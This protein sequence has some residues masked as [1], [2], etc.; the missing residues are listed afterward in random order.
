MSPDEPDQVTGET[1]DR[2]PGQGRYATTERERR[3]LLDRVPDGVS[4]PV[5]ILD[6]YIHA[7]TLRL[8]QMQSARQ[9]V[10]KL[11][12]KVRPD[13]ERPSVNQVT[14]L[15]LTEREF[16]I[17]DQLPGDALSKTRWR[18]AVGGRV[19]SVDQYRGQLDGLVLAEIE[20]SGALPV[21]PP[22]SC[23]LAEVTQD[24]RYTGGRLASMTQ[25]ET[26]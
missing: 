18:W 24:E 7:S 11:G 12:Q 4:D 13:P 14:N 10:F 8:R 15:Y 16:Q 19:F 22:P 9:T 20:T 5:E 3:W 1:I 23:V 21:S 25:P 2:S 6:K 26:S 17:F